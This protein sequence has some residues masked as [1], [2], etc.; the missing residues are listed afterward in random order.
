MLKNYITIAFRNILN[1]RIFAVINILGLAIGITASLIIF[2]YAVNELSFDKFNEDYEDIF[3]IRN[4]RY[5]Q[6]ELAEDMASACNACGRTIKENFP[7]VE[8]FVLLSN[9][10]LEGIVSYGDLKYRLDK[11]FYASEGFFK[12]FSYKLLKGDPSL[13]LSEPNTIV[14]SNSLSKKYFQDE[15]PIGKMLRFNNGQPMEITGVFEDVPGNSHLKFDILISFETMINNFGDWLTDSWFLDVPLTYVKLKKG[16]DIVEFE[17]GINE[18]V[19]E[20][21]GKE[22][23]EKGE[24]MKLFLQPLKDIHLYSNY[25]GE[26]E[27]NGDAKVVYFLL[28]LSFATILIAWVNY[29]NLSTARSLERA[30]EVGLRKVNGAT[31]NQLI[32]QF[33]IESF[34]LNL[35]A[36]ILALGIADL[37]IPGFNNY[38]GLEIKMTLYSKISFWLGL[39]IVIVFGSLLSGLYPAFIIS[40]HKPISVLKGK[41]RGTSKGVFFRKML[42]V[43]QFAVSILLISGT[44]TVYK[45]V[46]FMQKQDLGFDLDKTLILKGPLVFDSTWVQKNE[47]FKTELLTNTNIENVCAS[48]FVPGDEVWFTLVFERLNNN[49]GK[50]RRTLQANFI[51]DDFMNFYEFDLL[52]GRNFDE[53]IQ[54]DLVAYILNRTA[55]ELMG[56]E[57]PE[58]AINDDIRNDIWNTERKVI[59]VIE[60]YHQTSLK[61]NFTPL[62]YLLFPRPRWTKN[63]SIKVKTGNIQETIE[64]IEQKYSSFYPGNIFEYYFL[65][66]HFNQQ[67]KTDILFGK[68]FTIFSILAI[69]IACLGLFALALYYM[70][71]RMFEITIRKVHGA[72]IK[73]IFSLLSADYI[74]LFGISLLLGFPLSYWLMQKWLENYAYPVQIGSWFFIIPVLLMIIILFVSI[75]FLVFKAARKN[76]SDVLKYE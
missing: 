58:D 29:I 19:Q 15:D 51:D 42:I 57:K 25:P 26:A 16:T 9:F 74:Q 61:G 21:V 12:V 52:A 64:F 68:V 31:R 65:D 17:S 41:L 50:A 1:N 3:R 70:L 44:L 66:K 35:F 46:D 48:Y 59:G 5:S 23:K 45:Q 62:V 38:T 39:F 37:V 60:N 63:Y 43:F 36:V 24:D 32:G 28:L 6:G 49:P 33:L 76:P 27:A 71:Q 67:Y 56:Y 13:V 22:L 75:A 11:A 4:E 47:N 20:R 73:N 8:E 18:L 7:Q 53:R 34:V 54:T 40:S 55:M 72:S 69:F 10:Q 14:I 30:K 2:Q